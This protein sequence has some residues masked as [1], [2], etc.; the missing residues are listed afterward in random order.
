MDEQL[1]RSHRVVHVVDRPNRKICVTMLRYNLDRP[2]CSYAQ[3]RIFARK[4]EEK[5]FQQSVCVKYKLDEVIY[6]PDAMKSVFDK[7]IATQSF[8]KLL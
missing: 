3:V 7:C 6:L 5:K 2:A 1:I 4:T 8:C